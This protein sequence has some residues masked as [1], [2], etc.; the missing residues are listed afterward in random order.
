M[1]QFVEA[2]DPPLKGLDDDLNFESPR[3]GEVRSQFYSSQCI[4]GFVKWLSCA[5]ICWNVILSFHTV[6]RWSDCG[7]DLNTA[8]RNVDDIFS[9]DL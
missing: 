2:Y 1:V 8:Q 9:F 3:I 6:I 7:S 4:Y 5:Y